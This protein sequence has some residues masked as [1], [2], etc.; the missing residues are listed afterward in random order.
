M[1]LALLPKHSDRRLKSTTQKL[2]D[3][4]VTASTKE[5]T[6]ARHLRETAQKLIA[7]GA[8]VSL[9]AIFA[10]M[11]QIQTSGTV[12]PFAPYDYQ[13]DLIQSIEQSQNTVICKSR[14]MGVSETICCYLL[15]RALTEPGFSAVVFS[16]TQGDS[17]EL[18][19]R[20]RDMAISLGSLC[21]VLTS[22]SATKLAFK[23]LGRIH[24]LPVTARAARGIPSVSVILFDEAAFID[25]IDGV[26]QAAMPTLSMLGDRGKVI[27]NS[28]P[29]GRTGLF[30]RL[31]M[32]GVGEAKRVNETLT[33]IRQPANNIVPFQ[34]GQNPNTRSWEHKK[35]AKVFLH[36][37]SHPLY[38]ADPEWAEKTRLERQLTTQAWDQEY[39]L[40]FS[41][42]QKNVFNLELIEKATIGRLQAPQK[43][44]RYLAGID[45]NFGGA[46]FFRCQV[47][48]VTRTP[49]SLAAEYGASRKTKD[50]SISQSLL[51]LEQYKPGVVSVETNSGGTLILEDLSQLKAAWNWQGVCTTNTSKLIN[52]DRLI[53][54]LEREQLQFPADSAIAQEMPHFI[55]TIKG[56]SR[57]RQAE[58]GMHDDAVMAAAIA[59]ASLDQMPSNV[60]WMK[61]LV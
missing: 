43:G 30:Y 25:G 24:F 11:T 21:P 2:I 38:G 39:E 40:Q 27:F 35:W 14:Q 10:P 46:D 3:D 19:R 7:V 18:G 59:F 60:N 6:V 57:L 41:E 52:T 9:W 15:M 33:A 22:E 13:I 12:K 58:S 16:K 44:R 8:F 51:L 54:L 61:S 20:I 1:S 5:S 48:D 50:Y 23:G 29:N 42:G 47:W 55:E 31:I 26:Y 56:A 34:R 49:Y 28:T 17:S 4:S 32:A 53:L 45:P 37:R 36:W